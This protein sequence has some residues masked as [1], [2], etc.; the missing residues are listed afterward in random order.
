[1]VV[2]P[3]GRFLMGW[4][5]G[6]KNARPVHEVRIPRPFAIGVYEVTFE[7][8]RRCRE[9]QACA[10]EPDNHRWGRGRRP[11]I[12]VSQE[13]AM[14][15][16]AYLSDVT[17][18]RYRLPS[19]AEWE[20]AAR[21]GTDT[22]YWWGEEPGE[23]RA[24][25]RK[26]GSEWAGHLSAPVG[27]FAPNPFGLYDT[28][29]N[30]WKWVADLLPPELRGRADRRLGVGGRRLRDALGARRVVVLQPPRHGLGLAL[31]PRAPRR[32]LQRRLSR[33]PRP[34]LSLP[35]PPASASPSSGVSTRGGQVWTARYPY[36]AHL[37]MLVGAH[38]GYSARLTSVT[39]FAL[40]W[41][42]GLGLVSD[43]AEVAAALRFQDHRLGSCG[44]T[45]PRVRISQ[46]GTRWGR[47][48]R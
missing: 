1:M 37:I 36:Y 25:C 47:W 27:S 34:R 48:V 9:A 29:G 23:N 8:W 18:Q 33:R 44:L 4:A 39:V 40:R 14:A 22:A 26:C 32:Q 21:A 24:N 28:S 45:G 20:F 12:N 15:Y 46:G 5:A 43:E 42:S 35:L 19:E 13:D 6:K 16:V 7:E 30:V 41:T 38:G 3:G 31:R 2:V 11:V 10:R 17:G